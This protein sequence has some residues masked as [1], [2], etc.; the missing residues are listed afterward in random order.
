MS[1]SRRDPV[2]ARA[3]YKAQAVRRVLGEGAARAFLKGMRLDTALI[4]RVLAGSGERLR[5]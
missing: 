1:Y 3:V 4:E 2:K 5:R